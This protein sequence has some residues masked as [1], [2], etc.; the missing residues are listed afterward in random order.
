M[1]LSPL[2]VPLAL[3]GILGYRLGIV[4][5]GLVLCQ[6]LFSRHRVILLLIGLEFPQTRLLVKRLTRRPGRCGFGSLFA[7]TRVEHLE[8]A[9]HKLD[10]Y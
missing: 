5:L 8:F 7:E 6:E 2:H 10:V 9:S 4:G 1:S 3:G